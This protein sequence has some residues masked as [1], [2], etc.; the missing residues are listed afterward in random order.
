MAI[1]KSKTLTDGSV[2]EY[3]KITKEIFNKNTLEC[4]WEI[5]LFKDKTFSDEGMPS[6][7]I[8]KVYTFNCTKEEL[9]GDR[10]ELGYSKIRAKAITMVRPLFGKKEDA[11]IQFDSDIAGGEDV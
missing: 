7:P 9:A 1:K 2:G 10:T 5:S 11:L 3:W 4:T 8:R 6:L